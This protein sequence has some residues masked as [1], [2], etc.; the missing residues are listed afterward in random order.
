MI[1]VP[2]PVVPGQR[3]TADSYNSIL[4]T[5]R[6][7]RPIGGAGVLIEETMNGVVFKLATL[8]KEA[9]S[10]PFNH[11]WKCEVVSDA[12]GSYKLKILKGE[13]YLLNSG[14]ANRQ[15]LLIDEEY[16]TAKRL[17]TDGY[18]G[19]EGA[20]SVGSSLYI[21]YD[22][23]QS[24]YRLCLEDFSVAGALAPL[25][26]IAELEMKTDG[27][28][29]TL[30]QRLFQ[31]LYYWSVM[32]ALSSWEIVG[33]NGAWYVVDPQWSLSGAYGD[34]LP[35]G[36]A[37]PRPT[38]IDGFTF[39]GSETEAVEIDGCKCYPLWSSILERTTACATNS[40]VTRLYAALNAYGVYGLL[41]SNDS[42]SIEETPAC[43]Y[44][45]RLTWDAEGNIA[46]FTQARSG[47]IQSRWVE[48]EAYFIQSISGR[49][50]RL[51]QTPT[52]GTEGT[53]VKTSTYW[54][55]RSTMGA[56]VVEGETLEPSANCT[57]GHSTP[58]KAVPGNA[59]TFRYGAHWSVSAG[60]AL[61]R[62]AT[63]TLHLSS[64]VETV[65]TLIDSPYV[66]RIQV[67][68]PSSPLEQGSVDAMSGTIQVLAASVSAAAAVNLFTTESVDT[69]TGNI[70]AVD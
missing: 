55:L 54:R 25:F 70:I 30:S 63:T 1:P 65:A 53:Q 35:S 28:A 69:I 19:W 62:D 3:I 46:T 9:A 34:N 7:L 40:N 16:F 21:A 20:I 59:Y 6:M 60:G 41:A 17:A 13:L 38:A 51:S 57:L 42:D 18:D 56:Y 15:E 32:R 47:L 33:R 44:L 36:A 37:N 14:F 61:V 10:I 27:S 58:Q 52:G 68:Y 2:S 31:D 66:E 12:E 11:P 5:L 24:G 4:A 23:E 50:T 8:P 22:S 67:T 29:P 64:G 45:G 43:I 26:I 48:T 49:E 39:S